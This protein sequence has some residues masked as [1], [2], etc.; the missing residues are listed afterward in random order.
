MEAEVRKA[1][2][3]RGFRRFLLL[4]RNGEEAVALQMAA[5]AEADLTLQGGCRQPCLQLH[6]HASRDARR[7]SSSHCSVEA[8]RYPQPSAQRVSETEEEFH[9][10]IDNTHRMD[11]LLRDLDS[12]PSWTPSLRAIHGEPLPPFSKDRQRAVHTLTP[13]LLQRQQ[14][15]G[16]RPALLLAS[17]SPYMQL[18]QQNSCFPKWLCRAREGME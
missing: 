3:S 9:R 2:F 14:L 15:L 6:L 18:S 5:I 8:Y 10:Q 7:G 13:D 11:V 1:T 17:A 12:H 16:F 4:K